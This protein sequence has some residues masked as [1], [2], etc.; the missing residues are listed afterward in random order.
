MTSKPLDTGDLSFARKGDAA[1]HFRQ[2]LRRHDPGVALSEP[3]ATHVYWL[4]CTEN[5]IRAC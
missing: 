1:E 2:I 5:P 3:D 4:V